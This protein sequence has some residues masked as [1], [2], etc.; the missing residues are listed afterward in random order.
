M[1]TST[2]FTFG[3]PG[4]PVVTNDQANPL[5]VL[6]GIRRALKPVG[7]YIAQDIQGSSHHHGDR[8]HPLGTLLYTI[9]CMHCMSVSLAQGG[10]GL[11]AM[12]G[13]EKAEA[14]CYQAGFRSVEVHELQHDIQNFYYVCRP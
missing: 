12:W 2:S 5:A 8:D 13:R 3:S 14:Y 1:E 10:E 6:T 4:S 9:S 7:V 11:G